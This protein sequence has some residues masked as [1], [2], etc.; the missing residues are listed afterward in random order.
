M[1]I[2]TFGLLDV[3]FQIRSVAPVA[4]AYS[5]YFLC[6]YSCR[7]SS[8]PVEN[9]VWPFGPKLRLI[10][11]KELLPGKQS[12]ELLA[13]YML[14]NL[15]EITWSHTIKYIYI[16]N[17]D[18]ASESFVPVALAVWGRSA[19]LVI[20]I[21]KWGHIVHIQDSITVLRWSKSNQLA[22]NNGSEPLK[23]NGV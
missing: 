22:M 12:A 4:Q 3:G 21:H 6:S 16:D 19:S 13:S 1:N 23:S 8:Y 11:L 9:N 17:R 5:S 10:V 15:H 18:I 7:S 14:H 2:S 20:S